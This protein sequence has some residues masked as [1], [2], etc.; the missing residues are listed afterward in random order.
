MSDKRV[1][2]I[3]GG[4]SLIHDVESVPLAEEVFEARRDRRRAIAWTPGQWRAVRTAFRILSEREVHFG[5]GV[6]TAD[7][8][9]AVT[10][11]TISTGVARRALRLLRDR[12]V[13]VSSPAGGSHPEMFYARSAG[14]ATT[15]AMS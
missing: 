1:R 3:A 15:R 14:P 7:A 11:P 4:Y 5:R 12:G 9:A 6:V 10:V 2:E 8:V 13:L